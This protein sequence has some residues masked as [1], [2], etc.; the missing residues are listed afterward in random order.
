VVKVCRA[1]I[2]EFRAQQKGHFINITSIAGLVNLP[3]GSFTIRR[4]MLLSFSECMAYE[5]IDFNISVSTVQFEIHPNF[6]KM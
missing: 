5:L 4:N 3:L 2:P 1:F 6:Q